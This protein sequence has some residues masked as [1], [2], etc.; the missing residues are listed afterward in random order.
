MRETTW[1]A[2]TRML[3]KDE[4]AARLGRSAGAAILSL[5]LAMLLL[6]GLPTPAQAQATGQLTGT[7]TDE[8]GAVLPGVS[9]TV[10]NQATNQG[11][12]V[13][14]GPDGFFQVPLLAPGVYDVTATLSGFSTLNR[15]G[16]KVNVAETAD[17]ALQ[18]A[19]GELTETLTVTGEAPLVETSNA[20]LGIVIEEKKIVDLPLNGRNFTQLGTLIPG[21][22]EPPARLGG[23]D[24][25]AEAGVNGFG[26]V[27]SGFSVNGVRNQSN[28]FLLDG[29]TNNDTFNTGFVVR[30]PPDAIQEFKILT[31]SYSAEFGR[32]AGSVV[33][34][35]TKSG[36]NE[37][38]GSAWE[39]NRDDSLEAR[40]FFTP[41]DQDSV[42]RQ[43][44]FG[45][46]L[47]G[48]VVKD[49]FFVFGYYEG[50]RN[51]EG[52]DTNITVPS[53]AERNGDFSGSGTITDPL[54]GLPFP[55]NVIPAGRLDPSALQLMNDFYPTANSGS[56]RF[57]DSP[58]K[59]DSRNQ[60]GIRLDLRP[61]ERHGLLFRY[62][63][64]E[65]DQIEPAVTRPIDTTATGTLQDFMASHTFT[66]SSNAYNVLRVS[67]NTIDAA[68][69]VTSGIENSQYGLNIANLN[70]IAVGLSQ[71]TISGF[72]SMGDRNQPF[73]KR[74]N[75]V[76]QIT[77]DFTYLSGRHSLKFGVDIRREKMFIGFINRPNGDVGFNGRHT[78]NALADF[79]LGMPFRF[80]QASAGADA[81]NE[82][83]GWLYAGYVQDEFR[84][85]PNLTLNW[86]VR[87][88]LPIPFVDTGD[89]LNSFRP[90][91]QSTR[92]PE[93]PTSLVYPGDEGVPRS[94]TDTD[95][96]NIAPRLALAWDPTGDGRTSVRAGW[97]IF[98][99][100]LPGQG[101]FFQNAVLAPPFN[102]L[103][104]I[105]SP[106]A[107]L[108]LRDP[109]SGFSGGSTGFPPGII[110]IGWGSDFT[111]PSYQHYNLTVQRQLGNNVGV[112]V[113]Y[114]GSRG[115]N[116]PIF[117]ET[118][119]RV[120]Q[121]DGS[122]G[123]RL[124]PAF[125][126]VRPTFTVAKSWYDSLQASVRMRPTNG[127]NF[128][129]SYT[130]GHSQDHV[131]GLN[132][133][134]E[135]RPSL[136]VDQNDPA[137][138]DRA[139]AYEKGDSL[140]DV[141]HRFVLSFG[142]ELPR[143]EDESGFAKAVLGGWQINGIFQAQ[144]GSPFTAYAAGDTQLGLTDRA[145]QICDP[146]DGP[147]TADE[148][149]AT[150]CFRA[151][152]RPEQLA[153]LSNQGRN[154][155]RGPGFS[156]V[157]LSLFKNFYFGG[158]KTLQL[159]VEAFNVFDRVNLGTPRFDI[160]PSNFGR[161][162][163]TNGDARIIQLGVKFLF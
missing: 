62:L 42:L 152:S 136:A 109:L 63:R 13:V 134:G 46:S 66:A 105:N 51:T 60:Y 76:F 97:G 86:G 35:V 124:F 95:K 110:F 48:P 74:E 122:V 159:R 47:G 77:D 2:G 78:G 118:N 99:D 23:A 59:T 87:Y 101:D 91:Q 10:T 38:H 162:T 160:G 72:Q 34:V 4:F 150:D 121:A 8:S 36:S 116:L 113:G 94:T 16:V 26:A 92:F 6:A 107:S 130:W 144:T 32:N 61:N 12:T 17:V 1:W 129:A 151:R 163:S 131:S 9:I 71:V 140:F 146:N 64:S 132:I 28:N 133:G 111:T 85:N 120:V 24:G 19:V 55:G 93:A 141:R 44:Q 45:A 30:P 135:D 125:S 57:I 128:L 112:E 157:D 25:D 52:D 104:Q 89:G 69:Q 41:E 148:W 65:T 139:L 149:F 5:A 37:W 156:R 33:N 126:L 29:T 43:N 83:H 102:P 68:P 67:Y 79:L 147:K 142:I 108:S 39:F 73:V 22:V 53:A 115:K 80:R 14:S 123:G 117:I 70:A 84:V 56:N 18:L 127:I 114:V 119:P 103:L 96:N 88:E 90:G 82:G 50:F 20:T 143:M 11:R 54:T 138:I 27:T 15:E 98:Y 161:I 31:H 106:P 137:S 145:E 21:V 49:K 81:I 3:V 75:K 153:G 154:T 58:E 40:N 158:A 7:V 100:T 155:V